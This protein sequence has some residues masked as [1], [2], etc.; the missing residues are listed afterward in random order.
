MKNNTKVQIGKVLLSAVMATICMSACTELPIEPT[1]PDLLPTPVAPVYDVE[2]VWHDEFDGDC[3]DR[4]KWD[5]QLGIYDVYHG[6]ESNTLYWG[7]DELQYYTQDAVSVHDG[8]LEIAAERRSYGDMEFTSGR[9]LTRDL[10]SFT[11]G[12]FES[13]MRTPALE[14]MWPAFWMLPQPTSTD[15]TQNEYGYWASNGEIDIMEAKGRLEN[16][17]DNTLH[18]G[19]GWPNNRYSGKSYTMETSTEEWHVYA[20]DWRSDKMTWYIDGNATFS[21]RSSDWYT[22]ASDR[23]GA[24]FDVP[25]YILFDL[26]VGGKYDG[27]RRPSDAFT[28][29]SMYVDYVRVYQEY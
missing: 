16:I 13:R 19:G 26:A 25:F 11:F 7:N 23:E 24:P 17:I 5:Y 15:S 22:L 21:L 28:T 1:P 9:I 4:S 29:A 12:Y 10:A 8:M 14:G 27:G 2:L 3:L 6:I 18:Y 20:L